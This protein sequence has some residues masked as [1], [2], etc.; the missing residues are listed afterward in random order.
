MKILLLLL[1]NTAH[2]T[3]THHVE[4]KPRCTHNGYRGQCVLRNTSPFPVTCTLNIKGRTVHTRY[5]DSVYVPLNPNGVYP[6][7]VYAVD[8]INDP[9][10]S[11]KAEAFCYIAEV[12]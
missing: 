9:I 12:N 10:V 8:P 1:I 4:L 5:F 3:F 7:T 6:Y 11:L 2:A